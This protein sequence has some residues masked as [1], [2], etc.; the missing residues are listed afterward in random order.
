MVRLL[1]PLSVTSS[2][3]PYSRRSVRLAI[4][5]VV[6]L[7][8]TLMPAASSVAG[9]LNYVYDKKGQLI[10][11]D[12]GGG[13]AYT[14]TYDP[15]GNR[16][17]TESCIAAPTNPSTAQNTIQAAYNAAAPGGVIQIR[18]LTF[19]ENDDLNI[20]KTVTLRGGFDCGFATNPSYTVIQGSVFISNGTVVF[21]KIVIK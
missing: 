6:M 17:R 4:T 21:E 18:N 11:A 10:Q 14:Y 8:S 16:I 5:A 15:A 20:V 9:T 12:Y 19:A 7:C 2:K 13:K 3:S 1:F